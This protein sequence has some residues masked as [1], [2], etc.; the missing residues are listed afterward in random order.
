MLAIWFVKKPTIWVAII[1]AE[2]D[3]CLKVQGASS[4]S[5]SSNNLSSY[6]SILFGVTQKILKD[7]KKNYLMT[8]K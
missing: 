3:V 8:L 1:A 2:W 5:V 4:I 7:M 6:L